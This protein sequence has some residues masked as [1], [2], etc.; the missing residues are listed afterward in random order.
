MTQSRVRGRSSGFSL[1]EFTAALFVLSAG[2]LGAIQL[3]HVVVDKAKAV[4]E[5][6]IVLSA[7]QNELETLRAL[8]FGELRDTEDGRFVSRT[9]ALESLV[10]VAPNVVISGCAG[11]PGLKEVT[12]SIRWTGDS[13]RTI[14]K[15][16]TT[17][18]ADRG[19]P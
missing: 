3:Y 9:P 14:E 6:A 5:T 19:T 17:L 15:S 16:V 2:M 4:G 18:I 1:L 13:G 11:I 7:I 10:N 8:P 12:V